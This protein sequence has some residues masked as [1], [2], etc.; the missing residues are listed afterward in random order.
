MIY[1]GIRLKMLREAANL[2]QQQLADAMEVARVS[3]SKYETSSA[4]PTVEKLIRLAKFF[5]VSTDYL[6]GLTDDNRFDL[7]RLTD[8]QALAVLEIIHQYE[9]L[10]AK[11]PS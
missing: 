3:I 9:Q 8:E 11:K 6:L 4:Y 10:N 2:S 7:D 1:F 5:R